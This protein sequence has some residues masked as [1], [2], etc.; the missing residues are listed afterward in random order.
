MEEYKWASFLQAFPYGKVIKIN[1]SKE[2]EELQKLAK[3]NRLFY[4][5][6]FVKQKYRQILHILQINAG[7]YAIFYRHTNGGKQFLVEYSHNGFTFGLLNEYDNSRQDENEWEIV[8][9]SF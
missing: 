8:N 2:L 9:I 1:N 3:Q 5:E 6:W 4:Y 7:D